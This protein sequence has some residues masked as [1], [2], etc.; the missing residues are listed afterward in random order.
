MANKRISLALCV[1]AILL[2]PGPVGTAAD[3]P[4]EYGPPKGTLVIV[5]GGNLEG[6]G[7]VEKFVQ[8]AGG[9]DASFVIV[10]TAGGNKNA[11][12]TVHE[13]KESDVVAP[14]LKRGIKN[15]RM[16]HTHDSKLADTEA[17]ASVLRTA[18]AVWFNGGR[19]W[20]I[21]DSYMH[22]LT[23]REFH[24]VL[25]RGGVIG[26]SSAGATIQGDYLVRGAIAGPQIMMTPEKEH[27][28]GFK[29]LRRTA[30][31]Q[32]IN[33]RNRWDDLIPVIQKM[34]ELLG[35]GLSEST[36]II[37]TGDRFEVAGK[38]KVAIHDGTRLYQP[39][40]KPYFVLSAGDVY[41]MKTR[42]IEK[43]GTGADGRGGRERGREG[44]LSGASKF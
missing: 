15:V 13:Y 3:D 2:A 16:L 24:N 1:L 39:W 30:I 18:N 17:F 5:G 9:P 20:N 25:A 26:G 7:I 22:T 23:Y 29:F 8:L 31:D 33:T 40:E 27:E 36:A 4:P 32:H 19:Q 37:V 12:G 43:L 21:V 34:P 28:R 44:G 38:W 42:K 35:I 11:D 6:T 10:P 41:N 14:W